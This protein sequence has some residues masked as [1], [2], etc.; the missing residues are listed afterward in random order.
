MALVVA[1]VWTVAGDANTLRDRSWRS[2]ILAAAVLTWL[3]VSIAASAFL[4]AGVGV[5]VHCH[6]PLTSAQ[7][8][9]VSALGYASVVDT[10]LPAGSSNLAAPPRFTRLRLA[11]ELKKA[12]YC[13]GLIFIFSIV[14]LLR[15]LLPVFIT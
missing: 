4:A 11:S 9:P 2:A 7:A 12:T 15:K 13:L 5:D 10:T 6:L 14:C 1:V 3:S 8:A